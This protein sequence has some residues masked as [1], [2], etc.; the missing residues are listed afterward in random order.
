M[1]CL[2][3]ISVFLLTLCTFF[4]SKTAGFHVLLRTIYSTHLDGLPQEIRVYL[5]RKRQLWQNYFTERCNRY[6]KKYLK[7]CSVTLACSLTELY[8]AATLE[9]SVAVLLAGLFSASSTAFSVIDSTICSYDTMSWYIVWRAHRK[10]QQDCLRYCLHNHISWAQDTK[11]I[12]KE[13]ICHL[14][15]FPWGV[16]Q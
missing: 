12:G 4:F 6:G 11:T 14:K 15:S 7:M 2:V 8:L 5:P 1:F 16:F 3:K 10:K 13:S 9:V